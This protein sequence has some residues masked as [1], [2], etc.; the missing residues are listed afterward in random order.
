MNWQRERQHR[1]RRSCDMYMMYITHILEFVH[2]MR[3]IASLLQH[4]VQFALQLALSAVLITCSHNV[5]TDGMQELIRSAHHH[6]NVITGWREVLFY[7]REGDS[8]GAKCLAPGDGLLRQHVVNDE[9]I[10]VSCGQL[11]Q[12]LVHEHVLYRFVAA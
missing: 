7:S 8:S 9:P 11:L 4:S 6:N 5:T 12:F 2:L 1:L 10:R 3:F